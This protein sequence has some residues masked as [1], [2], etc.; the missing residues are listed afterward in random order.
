MTSELDT[1]FKTGSFFVPPKEV[2]IIDLGEQKD[3]SENYDPKIK[4]M[5]KKADVIRFIGTPSD[6][7]KTVICNIPLKTFPVSDELKTFLRQRRYFNPHADLS[8]LRPKEGL[9][10]IDI[11]LNRRKVVFTLNKRDET[12]S[13]KA[14]R[15][16]KGEW[17]DTELQ[18]PEEGY[19]DLLKILIA[20]EEVVLGSVE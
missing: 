7:E 2:E 8:I 9:A 11:Q 12:I 17:I 5:V 13:F 4:E 3:T 16:D 18:L 10:E 19:N 6:G 20:E 14:M 1:Y 15:Q